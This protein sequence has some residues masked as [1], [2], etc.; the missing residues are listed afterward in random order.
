MTIQTIDP[1]LFRQAMASF[2]SGVTVVTTTDEDGRMVGFT[3]SAFSSLSMDPPLVLV[4]PSRTSA[5]YPHLVRGERFAIHILAAGQ[6]D[7]AMAFASKGADKVAALAFSVSD[8]GNPI[9]P[10]ATAV[11]ECR[12]WKDYDGGDHL[13]VVGEVQRIDQQD[14]AV[15]LYHR[16]KMSDHGA[17]VVA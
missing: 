8:L 12:L 13:I 17:E 2:A 15:L 11:I 6:Q 1:A 9:L 5:T 10:G 4:C 14:G 7:V 3:A 16:G